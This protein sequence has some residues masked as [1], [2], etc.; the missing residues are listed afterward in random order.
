MTNCSWKADIG[1]CQLVTASL[2][3]L[4]P[5]STK[6]PAEVVSVTYRKGFLLY[7]NLISTLGYTECIIGDG[8]N[9]SSAQANIHL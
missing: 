6:N 8:Q 2:T 3:K 4:L 1:N 9:S 5:W 7:I